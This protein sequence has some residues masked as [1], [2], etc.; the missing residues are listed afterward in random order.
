MKQLRLFPG[1]QLKLAEQSYIAE[2]DPFVFPEIKQVNDNREYHRQ[3][4]EKNIG[5]NKLHRCLT[6]GAFNTM[7][8]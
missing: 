7:Q 4:T 1:A 6:A 2:I 8:N 3:K 5:I